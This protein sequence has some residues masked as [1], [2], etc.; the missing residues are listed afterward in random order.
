MTP[1]WVK[2]AVFYQIFPDRFRRG[3]GP[4][5][6]PEPS[7]N[8]YEPWPE[9]PTLRGFKGGN[10]WGVVERL[11]YIKNQGFN[12]LYFCPVFT[13][14]ANHRYHTSDYF[15]VDPMLGGNEA[16]QRVIKEAHQRDMRVILDG[17]FN[18]CGRAHFAFQHVIENGTQSPYLNWFHVHRFPLY[19]YSQKP[20]FAAW[21]DNPE[22]PKFNTS[23]PETREYLLSVA[24]YWLQQGIDGWRLDVPNEIDDDAFWREFRR[25]VRS[26]N[27]EAYIVGEI[28]GDAHRWLQ[29]DQF[30]AVMN[31]PL[32]RAILG[33]VGGEVL[34]RDLAAKSGLGRVEPLQ[35]LACSHRLEELFSKYSWDIVTAQMNILTSHDTP[36]IFTLLKGQVERVKLA[37]QALYTLPGAPTLYYGD[38]I[39]LEGQHDPDNRRGMIWEEERWQMPILDGVRKMAE[40]R[41]ALPALREGPYQRLYAHDGHLAFARTYEGQTIVV[42]INASQN[43]WNLHVPLHGVWTM[44]EPVEMLCGL[45]GYCKG[46]HLESSAALAP[47]SLGVWQTR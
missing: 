24:E 43:P 38:E 32:S 1:A 42:T 25:R 9:S 21:W 29:G 46:G 12:T 8:K 30:D 41:A 23:N 4:L 44:G 40:L 17:V 5:G 35:A 10:L 2:D 34:D 26:I 13:S 14:T 27:P 37:L 7:I 22:L 45:S 11:D 16:L 3:Q 20:N 47:H 33:F 19:A 28:W 18:H 31:Y 6:R 15:Q 36:R 39:G